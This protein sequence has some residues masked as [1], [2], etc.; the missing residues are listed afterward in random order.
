M[1][2]AGDVRRMHAII[3]RVRGFGIQMFLQGGW[4]GRGAAYPRV[5]VG[6]I[7]HHDASSRRSGEW[8]SLGYI[9][10]GS[11]IAPLSQFQVA[12]CLDGVPKIAV[13]ASGVCNHA[14]KGGPKNFGGT[15]VPLNNGNSWVYGAEKANDGLGEPMTAAFHYAT[16]GLFYAVL[17]VVA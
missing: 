13:V 4:E 5:P 8:G 1:G 2:D 17:E 10:S 15:T 7:D 14:G 6:I 9:L 16:N 3:N 12:R 11:P